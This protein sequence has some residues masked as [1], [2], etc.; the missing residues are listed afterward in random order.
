M[1]QREVNP[2]VLDN[3]RWGEGDETCD[4]GPRREPINHLSI[5]IQAAA[6]IRIKSLM[7]KQYAAFQ[8]Q[9]MAFRTLFYAIAWIQA[10]SAFIF[11]AGQTSGLVNYDL[12]SRLGLQESREEVP[13]SIVQVNRAFCASDTILYIPILISSSFGLFRKKRWSLICTA[14]SAGISSYWAITVTFIFSFLA[15]N[16]VEGYTHQVPLEVWCFIGFYMLF[17]VVVL[18]FLYSYWDILFLVTVH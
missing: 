10:L 16:N 9:D 17:G 13:E 12:A 2:S 6:S 18:A 1:K 3:G 15:Q 7:K 8:A 11:L 5:Q 14:A 4:L